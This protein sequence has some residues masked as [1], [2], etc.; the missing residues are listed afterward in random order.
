MALMLV[1]HHSELRHLSC[2]AVIKVVAG[3]SVWLHQ[4][5][6]K[7][8]LRKHC[9]GAVRDIVLQV[10]NVTDS[11]TYALQLLR[12]DVQQSCQLPGPAKVD[13]LQQAGQGVESPH[14]MEPKIALP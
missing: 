1:H 7:I 2:W 6:S 5:H 12:M 8:Q 11:C 4:C 10:L 13:G 14:F 3:H 9:L